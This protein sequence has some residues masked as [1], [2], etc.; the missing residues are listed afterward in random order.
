MKRG[1]HIMR[2]FGIFHKDERGLAIVE[3]TILLPVCIIMVAAVYYASIF[4]C[5]KANMQANLQNALIYYKNTASD[6]YVEASP[7]MAYKRE[8]QT[9]DADG[10]SYTTPTELFPYRFFGFAFDSSDFE[11]FFRSMAGYMFF[12]TG[13]NITITSQSHNYIIYKTI[14]ATATQE[15]RPAISLSLVGVPNSFTLT[16]TGEAVVTDADD[17]IRNVDFAVDLVKNTKLGEI[18]GNIAEKAES[19]YSSF[20]EKFGLD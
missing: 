13:D 6:T 1:K 7:N 16:V 9:I 18:A 2:H 4:M 15:V 20:R 11:S 10:S 12:D 17:F 5:Q 3:A 14:T 8:G 19:L